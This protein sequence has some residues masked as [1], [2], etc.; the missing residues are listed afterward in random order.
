MAIEKDISPPAENKT[1]ATA[2]SM[3]TVSMVASP[4][5]PDD[6]V[7]PSLVVIAGPELGRVFPLSYGEKKIGR[8]SECEI[9][10]RDETVSRQHAQVIFD[11]RGCHLRDLGSHNGTYING[12][13]TG[14]ADLVAGDRIQL[15]RSTLMRLFFNSKLDRD[16]YDWLF[17]MGTRDPVTQTFSRRYFEQ[18]FQA[19]F[20]LAVRHRQPLSLLI[21]DVDRFKETNDSH[22]HPA[23]DAL[24]QGLANLLNGRL[25][26]EDVLARYGGDEFAI[27]LCSTGSIGAAAL[28]QALLELVRCA[29]FT[30]RDQ[31]LAMTVSI[32]IATLDA[33]APYRSSSELLI[34]ADKALYAAKQS[35]RNCL[36]G[37]AGSPPE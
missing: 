20:A 28:A 12:V 11:D 27:V 10:I 2:D 22:G 25:R 31:L 4:I 18:H 19:S 6:G 26:R 7:Q 24:L 14:E 34:A 29:T 21:L 1:T 13:R 35:G 15:G 23:G 17:E 32:G 5:E 3:S 8:A 30:F 37:P 33:A 9:H 16:F 36:S